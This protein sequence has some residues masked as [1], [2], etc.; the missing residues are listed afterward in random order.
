VAVI[1]QDNINQM[2]QATSIHIQTAKSFALY[3]NDRTKTPSYVVRDKEYNEYD[4]T[5]EEAREELRALYQTSSENYRTRTRQ[6]LQVKNTL[7]EAVIVV[8]E[9]HTLEDIKAVAE[10][11]EE[12]T[13]YKA[14]QLSIHRANNNNVTSDNNKNNLDDNIKKEVRGFIYWI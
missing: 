13:G 4:K 1:N 5:A 8:D 7:A 2:A 10:M 11:I 3:H 14:I 9:G 12:K 6:K